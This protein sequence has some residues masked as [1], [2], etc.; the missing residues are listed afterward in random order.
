M[1]KKFI[2][3]MHHCQKPSDFKY[4]LRIFPEIG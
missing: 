2:L 1:S 4:M 3:A